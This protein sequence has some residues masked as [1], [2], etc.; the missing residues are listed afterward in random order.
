MQPD[1][2]DVGVLDRAGGRRKFNPADA[3]AWLARCRFGQQ[4]RSLTV[5]NLATGKD[6]GHML[7]G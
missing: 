5:F 2:D 4:D 3:A 7:Q 6:S 1:R